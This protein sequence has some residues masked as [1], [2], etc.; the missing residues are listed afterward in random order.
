MA[1][2][3][4]VADLWA[5]ETDHFED[6]LWITNVKKILIHIFVLGWN[7]H[8]PIKFIRLIK[9]IGELKWNSSVI[10]DMYTLN[11]NKIKTY[12]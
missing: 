4:N 5:F 10:G 3:N 11:N 6:R 7:R 9:E 8:F 1:A 2:I 12:M